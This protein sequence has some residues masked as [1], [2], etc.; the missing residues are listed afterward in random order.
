MS[1]AVNHSLFHNVFAYGVPHGGVNQSGVGGDV[2]S[3]E[4]LM[5]YYRSTSVVR[6]L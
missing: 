2:L 3:A 1:T 4:T 6:P 5:V